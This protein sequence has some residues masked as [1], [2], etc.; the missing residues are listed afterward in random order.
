MPKSTYKRWHATLILRHPPRRKGI[1][2]GSQ[3]SQNQGQTVNKHLSPRICD[4]RAIPLR[5][6]CDTLGVGFFGHI[7]VTILPS[8]SQFCHISFCT[9]PTWFYHH[10]SIL[11]SP[12]FLQSK[13]LINISFQFFVLNIIRYLMLI[14]YP[15]AVTA[16][17][18]DTK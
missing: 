4:T 12:Y 16:I 17:L 2:R 14:K 13:F 8:S 18:A 7:L 11:L 3:V 1:A 6:L 9:S 15:V 5:P 10:S